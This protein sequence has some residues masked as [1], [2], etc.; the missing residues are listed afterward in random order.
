MPQGEISCWK[1]GR[2]WRT[3]AAVCVLQFSF[4]EQ[5]QQASNTSALCVTPSSSFLLILE[6][7]LDW[8]PSPLKTK[9]L[10]LNERF[11]IADGNEMLLLCKAEVVGF[12]KRCPPPVWA[13]QKWSPTMGPCMTPIWAP[14][15]AFSSNPPAIWA[16]K[17]WKATQS[18]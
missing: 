4:Q 12:S 2:C 17:F 1:P 8:Q 13:A 18:S 9:L 11:Q 6:H 16:A 3:V 15:P 10:G 7:H 14:P 5:W